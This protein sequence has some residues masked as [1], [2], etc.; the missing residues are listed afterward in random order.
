MV[1]DRN[2]AECNR[3]EIERKKQCAGIDLLLPSFPQ[4][5]TTLPPSRN[6]IK[7]FFEITTSSETI[8]AWDQDLKL[9]PVRQ[10]VAEEDLLLPL[11]QPI[12][13]LRFRTTTHLATF[14]IPLLLL[15]P[16]YFR[17]IITNNTNN[18]TKSHSSNG[19]KRSRSRDR[20]SRLRTLR[21]L[22]D[23]PAPRGRSTL[24]I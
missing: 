3:A 6:S 1:L 7:N 19:D 9:L 15:Y 14:N 13:P 17:I 18:N 2:R 10:G 11:P 16:T 22:R 21:D 4:P 20:L 5:S 12:Q 23:L 24:R 8:S